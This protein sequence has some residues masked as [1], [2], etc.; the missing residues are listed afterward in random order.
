MLD[1]APITITITFPQGK[2]E[3]EADLPPQMFCRLT[4]GSMFMEF[5]EIDFIL[6]G[7]S[8]RNLKKSE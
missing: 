8:N 1:H 3:S 4:T 6:F 2:P 7:F 5:F